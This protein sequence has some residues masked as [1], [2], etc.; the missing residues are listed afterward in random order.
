MKLQELEALRSGDKDAIKKAVE[1]IELVL[2]KPE[3]DMYIA[4]SRLVAKL[5]KD[6]NDLADVQS[7]LLD[8]EKDDKAFDR[9]NT[10]IEN[11]SQ[12]KD[13]LVSGREAFMKEDDQEDFFPKRRNNKQK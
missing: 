9:I 13:S 2:S 10:I 3:T 11:F 6:I 12:Y 7:N 5:A 8:S 1:F 4:L